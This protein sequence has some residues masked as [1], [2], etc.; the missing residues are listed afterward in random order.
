MA[1]IETERR[2]QVQ[3]VRRH[4]ST[5]TGRGFRAGSGPPHLVGVGV[6]NAPILAAI[7]HFC[8]KVD[9]GLV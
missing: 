9:T 2:G 4:R 6:G 7:E 8:T 5:G 3:T 1:V